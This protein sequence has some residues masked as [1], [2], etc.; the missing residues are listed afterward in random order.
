MGLSIVYSRS[1]YLEW[2]DKELLKN[3]VTTNATIVDFT[4]G[5]GICYINYEYI[6]DGKRIEA[7]RQIKGNRCRD[8]YIGIKDLEIIYAVE[9]HKLSDVVDKRFRW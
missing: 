8:E 7:K 4:G 2:R 1:F 9:D 6:V 5:K 3:S